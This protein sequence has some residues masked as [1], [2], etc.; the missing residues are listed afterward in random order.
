MVFPT[1]IC[2]TT[3]R[4]DIILVSDSTKAVIMVELTSPSEENIQQRN[5]DKRKKYESL[6]EQCQLNNWKANLFCVEVGARGFVADSFFGAM[7]KLGLKNCEVKEMRRIISS[8]ALR[9]SYSIYIQRN[10][11]KFVKWKMDA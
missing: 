5:L 8:T 11:E 2:A 4:P 3:Q 9:C 6:I 7:K 1:Y 10:R